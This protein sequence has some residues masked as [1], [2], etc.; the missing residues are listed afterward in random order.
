MLTAV[1]SGQELK[2]EHVRSRLLWDYL[3]F[4]AELTTE[5]HEHLA[6]CK[7]CIETFR[8]CVLADTRDKMDADD[9][10]ISQSA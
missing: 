10:D 4:K 6:S 9:S 8:L 7:R 5:Q 3:N 2:P 1:R